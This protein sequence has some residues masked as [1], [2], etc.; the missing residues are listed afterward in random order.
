MQVDIGFVGFVDEK[1]EFTV[2]E[3]DLID[4][5]RRALSNINRH[6]RG[7]S[8]DGYPYHDIARAQI[9]PANQKQPLRIDFKAVPAG[10]SIGQAFLGPDQ[11]LTLELFDGDEFTIQFRQKIEEGFSYYEEYLL[12]A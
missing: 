9:W 7:K 12:G 11:A 6:F 10:R 2:E 3:Q 8:S 4:R 1:V 5:A